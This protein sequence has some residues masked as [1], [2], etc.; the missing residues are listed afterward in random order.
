MWLQ[1]PRVSSQDSRCLRIQAPPTMP[2]AG[3]QT[4]RCAVHNSSRCWGA[5]A[6]PRHI[7]EQCIKPKAPEAGFEASNSHQLHQL[8]GKT[9]EKSAKKTG[10]MQLFATSC[11][12]WKR[13]LELIP[14]SL[15]RSGPSLNPCEE[16]FRPMNHWGSGSVPM[17]ISASRPA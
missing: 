14:R 13:Y 15:L 2:Q 3:T 16:D 17:K 9:N 10:A 6:D 5:P 7:A 4:L 11:G 12:A 1:S 8:P